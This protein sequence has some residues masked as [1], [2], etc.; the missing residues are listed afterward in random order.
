MEKKKKPLKTR[1]QS[2]QKLI[3]RNSKP[4]QPCIETNIWGKHENMCKNLARS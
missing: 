4:K 3:S 2:S 1:V